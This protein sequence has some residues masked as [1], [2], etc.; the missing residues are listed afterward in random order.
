MASS[1]Q[2]RRTVVYISVRNKRTGQRRPARAETTGRR[3]PPSGAGWATA[4]AVRADDPT[5][6]QLFESLLGSLVSLRRSSETTTPCRSIP[7]I[8]SAARAVEASQ[9]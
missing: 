2:T 3:T 6:N 4:Q 1:F 9:F 5:A 7:G 8:V